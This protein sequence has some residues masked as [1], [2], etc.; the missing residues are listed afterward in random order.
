MTLDEQYQA[1][2]DDQRAYLLKLQDNFNKT[3]EEAKETAKQKLSGLPK[4]DREG[5]EVILKEQKGELEAALHNLKT[6]VDVSTRRTMRKLE[7]IIREKEKQILA[8]LEKQM[9]SL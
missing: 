4:E 1:A 3:C 9:A 7:E 2:I 6:E 5:R 8:D